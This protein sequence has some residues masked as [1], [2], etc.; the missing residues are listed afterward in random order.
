MIALMALPD[1]ISVPL[2]V[3]FRII[4]P[5]A[6]LVLVFCLAYG[7]VSVHPAHKRVVGSKHARD[8]ATYH[9]AV[10]E[11]LDGGDPY[12][13][14]ALSKRARADKTRKSVHPFFYPPPFLLGMPWAAG[15]DLSTGY[16]IFFWLSQLAILG[17][18]VVMRRWIGAPLILLGLLACTLTPITDSAKMGQANALVLLLSVAGLWRMSGGLV[19]AAGMAK[20]SPALYLFA[21][22]A[23]KAWRP[24]VLACATA[25][26]LSLAALPL[27]GLESQLRFYTDVLPGFSTGDYHGL[28]VKIALPANHSIPDLFNQYWPGP[29]RHTLSDVAQTGSRIVS[30]SVL[31]CLVWLARHRRDALG[32]A[33]LYAAFSV[34]ML[35]A[36][37]YTYEHHLVAALFPA[38]ALGTA[39][40]QRRLGLWGW[41]VAVPAYFFVAWPLYWL[42]PLQ[43][44]APDFKW[45]LQESKFFGLVV[46]GVLCA[47]VAWRSPI[48]ESDAT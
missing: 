10:A 29:D 25:V 1:P 5:R 41:F 18:L 8:Y 34:L 27:V 35:I 47:V 38:A 37:V 11:A 40:I 13:T 6:Q 48:Q 17:V 2:R 46:L 9:Y 44:M 31:A 28:T 36:P 45:Q 3:L 14:Q 20:M 16:Q 21:W 7:L 22:V 30:I 43:K 33:N 39:L 26:V 15:V 23:R 4:P 42:R 32:D 19:G 24:V 12:D